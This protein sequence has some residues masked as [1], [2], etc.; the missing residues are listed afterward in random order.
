MN[1]VFSV[2]GDVVHPDIPNNFLRLLAEG[3]DDGKEDDQLRMYA[4]QSYLA[5][6]EEEDALYPQK[7]LQVMSWVLGEYSSLVADVDPEVILTKLHSLLKKTFVTSETK[8]WIMAAVTKI[9]S[10][11][12]CSKTVDKLIREFSNSLDTYMRQYAFELKHLCEDKA[13]MKTLL[14]FDASCNDMVVDAS[15]SFLDGFVAEGL[16]R[17]AAPYKPHHQ[18]QEEK[19]SQEKALNFEPY[20]LAFASSVSSSGVTGRQSPT[21]L[22]FGSD[23]SGNSAETG[24]KETNTLKLEGVRK[25][26]GKEGYLPKKENKVGKENEPQTVSCSNL[27]PG[28]VGDPPASRSDQVATLSEE[29]KEK[30]QLA[31]TLFIGLGSNAGVSLMGK[32]DTATQKFKRKSKINETQNSEEESDFQNSGASDFGPLLDTVPINMEDCERNIRTRL[33]KA[34]L[35]SSD[36]VEDNL[37]FET[38]QSL[39]K[40]GLD[41]RLSDSMLSQ[42]SLFADSNIEIFQPSPSAQC[43]SA[44]KPP[45]VPS[46]PEELEELNHSGVVELCQSDA[47]ALYLCKVWTD[48]SLL[49]TVFVSNKTTSALNAVNL[50]FEEAEHF[51]ILE[52]PTYQFPVIEAQSVERCQK[53]VWMDKICTQGILSGSVNYQSEMETRLEFSITLSLLDFIRPMEITTEDFGKLW[54][55]LSNDVK[56]NIKMSCS[57]DSLS[58]ALNTLQQKLKLHIVDIIGNEGILACQLLPSVPCLLHCR[59]HSGMLALWFRSP[60]P[61]L[62]D[63]LLYQCQKVM[64]ES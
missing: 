50:V 6:L 33:R 64:E 61:A 57:Q 59:T 12:S 8:V 4:V 58:A 16:G 20:G 62:P 54:L 37:A 36:I 7:F 44:S 42:S 47:L 55:S 21:G 43:E 1:A 60:C 28:Q 25:L 27:L 3:F 49:L 22:S 63:G 23:T 13:L 52:S 48:D 39:K 34:S 24:H 2:G 15:L 10:R 14:P 45:L 11:T 29:D 38:P 31:S 18:R 56:Q 5:L 17:G 53:C 40:S 26:W 51:Q 32:A 9:A 41:D 35:C 19:L 46:L 30:Q